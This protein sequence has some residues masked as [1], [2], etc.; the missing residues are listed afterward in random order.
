MGQN[1]SWAWRI[2]S[3]LQGALPL[4]Q[5]LFVFLLP[6]SPRWLVLKGREEEAR[7]VLVKYHAGGD[8]NSPLVDFEMREIVEQIEFDKRNAGTSYMEFLKTPGNR[9][10]L[11]LTLMVPTMMQLSGNGLVSYYLHLVLNSIGMTSSVQQLRI[12]GG[13]MIFNWGTALASASFVEIAGRRKLFLFSMMGMLTSYVIWTILS[14]INQERDF[15]DSSLGKGVLTMIFIY[16][17]SYN[18]GLNGMP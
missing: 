2:P 1:D 14:A 17:L 16:Y 5:V 18:A 12:N 6:E 15:K 10:R 4:V 11:F 3:L 9:H 8:N 7:K 13:L